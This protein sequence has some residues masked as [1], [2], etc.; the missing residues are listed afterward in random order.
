[1]YSRI[2]K[3]VTE[4]KHSRPWR[5]SVLPE[6]YDLMNQRMLF[7]DMERKTLPNP[8]YPQESYDGFIKR[9]IEIKK[10]VIIKLVSK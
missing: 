7:G 6:S 2:P 10:D 5:A 8:E 4:F 1:L 9:I 3:T